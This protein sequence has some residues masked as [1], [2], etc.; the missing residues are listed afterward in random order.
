MLT[1]A[2]YKNTRQP[3]SG[4]PSALYYFIISEILL[5]LFHF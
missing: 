3:D 5:Q 1:F 2:Y 4:L